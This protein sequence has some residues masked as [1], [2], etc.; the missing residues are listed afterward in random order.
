LANRPYALLF[1]P[2]LP[3]QLLRFFRV[4]AEEILFFKSTITAG[5][6]EKSLKGRFP[7]RAKPTSTVVPSSSA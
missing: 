5:M 3:G 1:F 6:A 4:H 2:F 7:I